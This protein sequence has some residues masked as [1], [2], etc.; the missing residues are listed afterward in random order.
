MAG[1][2][3]Q[4]ASTALI[5]PR[6]AEHG[7]HRRRARDQYEWPG[8]MERKSWERTL[9]HQY[10]S[11]YGCHRCGTW[12]SSPHAVYSHLARRHGA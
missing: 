11:G 12:F 4:R 3:R 7:G 9:V 5:D 1:S 10:T 2:G 8:M 6:L